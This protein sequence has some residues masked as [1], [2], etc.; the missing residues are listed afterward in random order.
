MDRAPD[1]LDL[2]TLM[3]AKGELFALAGLYSTWKKPDG[4]RLMS[5]VILTT[6]ANE[7]MRPVHH[8]M[9][10]ILSRDLWDRWLDPKVTDVAAI[11]E[12]LGCA[13]AGT[14]DMY[15]VS[16]TVNSPSNDDER[17]IARLS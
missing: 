15:P 17:C 8:R 2:V 9:P 13:D 7:V 11:R 10:V 4:E 14:L 1:I 12:M 5:C 3:K 16:K 6:Q